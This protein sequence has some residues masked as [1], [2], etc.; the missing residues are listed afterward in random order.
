MKLGSSIG[1]PIMEN[2]VKPN[3]KENINCGMIEVFSRRFFTSK[4]NLPFLVELAKAHSA[5]LAIIHLKK[6]ELLPLPHLVEKIN[7]D[8]NASTESFE[9]IKKIEFKPDETQIKSKN[10][11]IEEIKKMFLAGDIVS[12]SKIS[13]KF[14]E[15]SK[16]TLRNHLTNAKNLLF[17]DGYEIETIG[18]GQFATHEEIE[19]I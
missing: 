2:L 8:Y 7:S 4:N 18:R 6:G 3:I 15:V 11:I 17:S 5:T 14:P 19:A 9:I 10:V 13:E 1:E 16:S 12:L